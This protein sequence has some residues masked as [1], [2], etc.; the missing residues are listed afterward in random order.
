MRAF[1]KG[2][3]GTEGSWVRAVEVMAF[4]DE[5]ANFDPMSP[6]HFRPSVSTPSVWPQARRI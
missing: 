6:V 4:W 5:G 3:W 2:I 1:M